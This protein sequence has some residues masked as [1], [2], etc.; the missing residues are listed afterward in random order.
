[1]VCN[2]HTPNATIDAKVVV[3]D[4][5]Q[6]GG[7][8]GVEKDVT[9]RYVTLRFLQLFQRQVSRVIRDVEE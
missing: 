7:G 9:L 5:G 4:L 3:G 1:M 2:N 8:L 6:G